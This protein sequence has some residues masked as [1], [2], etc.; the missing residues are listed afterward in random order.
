MK[1]GCCKFLPPILDAVAP[2]VHSRTAWACLATVLFALSGHDASPQTAR[3]IKIVVGVQAGAG[4]D[5]LSRLL[6]DQI[7]RAQAS[8][9]VI[10]NRPGASSIIATEAVARATP[11]GS[12]LLVSPNTILVTPYLQK[13]NFHPLTSFEPICKLVILPMVLVVNATS[14]YQT[15][16]DLLDAARAK[17]DDLTLASAGPV[18]APRL[19]VEMLKRMTNIRM[20]YVPYPGAA[21]AVNAL[22]GGHVTAAMVDYAG[23]AEQIKADRLRALATGSKRRIDGLPELPTVAE[24]GYAGYEAELWFGVFAP[25]KTPR[26]KVA[27]LTG[28]FVAAMQASDIQP[29]LAAQGFVP[30]VLCGTDFSVYLRKQYDDYGDAIRNANIK[31]E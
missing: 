15:L 14:P 24:S 26:E 11:D 16:A 1:I 30:S 18:G 2:P 25:G 20:T 5:I 10:E 27:Q 7:G 9:V 6:A 13:V 3:T 4:T 22:L 21:P 8:T 31:L 19:A 29:K 12:T 28:L 23:V 17:P